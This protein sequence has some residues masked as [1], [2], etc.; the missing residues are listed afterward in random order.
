MA[1]PQYFYLMS[2]RDGTGPTIG[3][4]FTYYTSPASSTP[5]FTTA[6]QQTWMNN[7][8]ADISSTAMGGVGQV[9][10][11]IHGYG[12]SYA[13][14]V[15]AFN[16]SN[17]TS[18]PGFLQNFA[19]LG[20]Y[21][22]P[23]IELDWPSDTGW[24]GVGITPKDFAQAK[25][26]A[27]ATGN[28]FGAVATLLQQAI[29]P[30][31]AAKAVNLTIVCHSMGNYVLQQGASNLPAAPNNL[32][33]Q[34]LLCASMLATDTF[35]VGGSSATPGASIVAAAA[36]VTSYYSRNDDVL[37]YAS[38]PEQGLDGYP[39]LGVT[40]PIF[41]VPAGQSL[42]PTYHAVDC[43][44]VVTAAA[45]S[46]AGASKVHQSYFFIPEVVQELVGTI[47]A[48]PRTPLTCTG[49]GSQLGP[50]AWSAAQVKA[51]KAL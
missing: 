38:L 15:A 2:N 39:E 9:L 40:G 34:I 32:A 25:A 41:N 16:P 36:R 5:D 10:L 11:F 4:S 45:A 18:N 17:A 44:P 3:T 27:T 24:K 14:A 19:A 42:P 12:V 21:P 49:A 48:P 37:P 6:E 35:S 20:G 50:V 7:L 30:T 43:T 31:G 33:Q 23:V 22:G 51:N 28:M 29:Q 46:Q 13:Q 1:T 26:N 8:Q 47:L